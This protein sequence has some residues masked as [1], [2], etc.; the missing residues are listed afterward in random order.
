[1]SFYKFIGTTF[2]SAYVFKWMPGTSSSL[3]IWM[4]LGILKYLNVYISIEITVIISIFSYLIG[5]IG[6]KDFNEDDPK[7]FTLDEAFALFLLYF[8]VQ[9][10]WIY[11]VITLLLFR[12]FDA[13]KILG[14]KK[15]EVLTKNY[16]LFSIYI[17]DFIAGIY[18]LI[19]IFVLKALF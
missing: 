19:C 15:V 9:D 4:I 2:G 6:I 1:M 16:R 5:Y 17:D 18:T 7:L 8:F 11:Y 3:F 13:T 10:S 12:F 14:I